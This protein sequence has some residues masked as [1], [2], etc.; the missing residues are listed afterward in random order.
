MASASAHQHG[1]RAIWRTRSRC[2][3]GRRGSPRAP[4]AWPRPTRS[5]LRGS[6]PSRADDH[7]LDAP[8]DGRGRGAH[9]RRQRR[10]AELL[11]HDDHARRRPRTPARRSASRRARSRARRRR[12]ARRRGSPATCS[13]AMYSGVPKMAKPRCAR[14]SSV[15]AGAVA[16]V[17]A[18]ATP[19]V[20]ELHDC[21]RA[22]PVG[23]EHQ[24]LRLE[25]AVHEPRGVRRL[26]RAAPRRSRA[27]RLAPVERP[28]LEARV[29]RLAG[30]AAPSPGRPA[31]RATCR[32]RRAATR[33]GCD[34]LRDGARLAPE[35]LDGVR[36][37]TRARRARIFSGDL[38]SELDVLRLVDHA[39]RA[40][41]D[42]AARAGRASR[43]ACAGSLGVIRERDGLAHRARRRRRAGRRSRR[44]P[45][46]PRAAGARTR[47]A[48]APGSCGQSLRMSSGDACRARRARRPRRRRRRRGGGAR[49]G[50]ARDAARVALVGVVLRQLGR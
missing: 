29:E 34:S 43:R 40:L 5:A 45:R 30:A 48:T 32:S 38:A 7:G 28:A 3:A 4:R 23:H 14:S 2:G 10:L 9:A 19:E 16:A 31:R 18:V 15:G 1:R 42:L 6:S 22:G 21:A 8:R 12:R 17:S 27:H 36:A 50:A 49:S 37:T 41:A 44:A 39:A 35:A 20:E 47:R 25:V 24:V 26:E 46:A 33:F 13:G 11:A